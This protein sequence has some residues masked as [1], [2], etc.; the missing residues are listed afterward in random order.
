MLI[1]TDIIENNIILFN[2]KE[3][4]EWVAAVFKI[5][6]KSYQHNNKYT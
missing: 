2:T 3:N 1:R 4:I 6:L 5:P